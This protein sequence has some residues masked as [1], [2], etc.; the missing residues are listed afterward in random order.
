MSLVVTRGFGRPK[1]NVI[2]AGPVVFGYGRTRVLKPVRIVE[3][4]HFDARPLIYPPTVHAGEIPAGLPLIDATPT[5]YSPSIVVVAHVD[6][7]HIMLGIRQAVQHLLGVAQIANTN[8]GIKPITDITT[9]VGQAFEA[10]MVVDEE[11]DQTFIQT[12]DY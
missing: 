11:F 3:P 7:I 8:V 9:G 10:N 6:I 1:P 5:L 4:L 12:L 2:S